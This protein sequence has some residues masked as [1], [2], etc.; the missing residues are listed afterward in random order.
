MLNPTIAKLAAAK[1][2]SAHAIKKWKTRGEVP[3]TRRADFIFEAAKIGV[4]LAEADF[5]IARSGKSKRPAK[6]RKAA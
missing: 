2:I 5:I 3:K 1:N 6:R 4:S